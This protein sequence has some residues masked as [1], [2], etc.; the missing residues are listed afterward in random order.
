MSDYMGSELSQIVSRLV[1]SKT[2]EEFEKNQ[3][4][5]LGTLKP[6][7]IVGIVG[8]I[9]MIFCGVIMII[10]TITQKE[11]IFT[12]LF[13]DGIFGAG[14]ILGLFLVLYTRNFLMIYQDGKIV[15]RNI[16]GRTRTYDCR[17]ITHV[18][19]RDNGG[20]QFVFQ[21]GKKMNFD[22]EESIFANIVV[23]KEKLKR[24]FKDGLQTVIK[25]SYHPAL[26]VPFW[27]ITAFFVYGALTE[28]NGGLLLFA[29]IALLFCVGLQTS[30]TTYDTEER[31][32]T[33]R[34]CGIP[35]RYQIRGCQAKKVYEGGFLMKIDI[36]QGK[37]KIV[38]VPVSREFKN[39]AKLIYVLCKTHV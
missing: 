21:N 13:C 2:I 36:F 24:E 26:T 16:L 29:I 7:Q 22:A 28:E 11:D 38:S 35:K 30:G 3:K 39:R 31:I 12:V 17:D 14:L 25:V 19:F 1:A 5:N 32:L 8:L 23:G 4:E 37:K 6:P 33:R 18:Y 34:R 10:V 15:Y 9:D 20:L 27:C